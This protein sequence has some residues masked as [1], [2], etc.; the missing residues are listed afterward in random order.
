MNNW[1]LVQFQLSHIKQ[2]LKVMVPLD[3]LKNLISQEKVCQ[4]AR[5]AELY[6]EPETHFILLFKH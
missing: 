3:F 2:L 4:N 6:T 5:V 1:N